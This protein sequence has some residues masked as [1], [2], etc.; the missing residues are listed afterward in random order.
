[1]YSSSQELFTKELQ[2][3]AQKETVN[4]L[5]AK[6]TSFV[7]DTTP[8]AV[9]YNKMSFWEMDVSDLFN[10]I[11]KR[12]KINKQLTLLKQEKQKQIKNFLVS[13]FVIVNDSAVNFIFNNK[14]QII[15]WGK[16]FEDNVFLVTGGEFCINN[17]N[18]FILMLDTGSGISNMSLYVFKKDGDIWDLQTTSQARLQEK[19]NIRVDNNQEKLIFETKSGQ[20]GELSF[21]GLL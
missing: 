6:M 13:N 10:R 1:M 19:L 16:I 5:Y 18:I 12:K 21:M 14:N 8:V 11:F 9:D 2:W 4:D 15:E 17:S 20:I 3:Q 7:N